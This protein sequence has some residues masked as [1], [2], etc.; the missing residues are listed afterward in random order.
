MKKIQDSKL[1]IS[2][3]I[4]NQINSK[5]FYSKRGRVLWKLVRNKSI[6]IYI[7]IFADNSLSE[8]YLNKLH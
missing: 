4:L 6:Y 8:T 5:H 1:E 3:A 7:Y 2:K